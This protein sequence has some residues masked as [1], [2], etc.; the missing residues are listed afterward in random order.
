MQTN[1]LA[2]PST[3]LSSHIIAHSGALLVDEGSALQGDGI[4]QARSRR[5]EA[6]VAHVFSVRH[7]ALRAA[8]RGPA[9]VA[10]A[11]QAA[12]YLC[13]TAL[14]YSLTSVGRLFERDRTTVSHAC[15]LVEDR[16]DDKAFDILMACLER[17][18][19]GDAKS[20]GGA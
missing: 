9:H 1:R 13:H 20:C 15:R 6:C 18:V 3:C 10:L 12:M 2:K 7:E 16:R 5:V 14:G 17:S 19:L 11:R 8:T 4:A